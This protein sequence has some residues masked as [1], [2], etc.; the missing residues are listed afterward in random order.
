MGFVKNICTG[1]WKTTKKFEGVD[2]QALL[3]EGDSQTQKQL[4][5]QLGVRQQPVSGCFGYERWERFRRSV[6]GYHM[7]WTTGKW[8]KAKTHI[9]GTQMLRKVDANIYIKL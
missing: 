7:S 8:K 6:D 3:N 2:L 4:A 1:T 9:L 5:E